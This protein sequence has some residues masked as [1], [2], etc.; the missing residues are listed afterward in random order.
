MTNEAVQI[1]VTWPIDVKVPTANIVNSLVINHKGAVG[2][3]Q[4]G[5]SSKDGVV[6]FHYRGG[7]LGSRVNR[8][9][10]FGFLAI[11]D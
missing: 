11:V 7:N 2:M 1:G 3:L 9:L 4:G 6:R 5:M 10:Q 8:K